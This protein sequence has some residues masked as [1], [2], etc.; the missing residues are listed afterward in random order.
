MFIGCLFLD[1]LPVL[2][3][4]QAAAPIPKAISIRQ[5]ASDQE[6]L[7]AY[8]VQRYVYLRT[9][10]LLK[11]RRG[12][13]TGDRIVVSCKDRSFCGEIGQDLAPQQFTLRT[14]RT[15]AGNLWWIVGGDAV[16]ALYGTYR[17]AEKLGVRFGIDEDILPQERLDGG[18]PEIEE[19]GKPRFALRGLQP[20]HD[21]SVGPDWWNLQDYKNVLS[22]MVKLR[23]NFF[24]L[25]TYP[26]WNPSAGPEANVWIGLP[27]DVDA[28]GNVRFGYESG[29]V[30]TRRGWEVK[31]YPTSRYA[32]GAG[33]F[34]E[35]D[36]YG[37]DFLLDWLDWPKTGDQ[38][39]AM[40]NQYGDF[41]ER[42]FTHA[43]RLGVKTC[44]GTEIPLGIPKGLA[45]CLEASEARLRPTRAFISADTGSL[46]CSLS[47]APRSLES[48]KP[49]KGRNRETGQNLT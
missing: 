45:A 26:S 35:S 47:R 32:S 48:L 33:L 44:V 11:V 49:G 17:F 41:Q 22:Q 37:P 13:G 43:R 20:F 5:E 10:K 29:V 39:A 9:G 27:E 4:T 31:P 8:E 19:T 14:S 23:M 7:A 38:A 1:L 6:R 21:F 2:L 25:H 36:D 12:S 30:T 16:G 40:F 24:G 15:K 18:M 3:P 42:A 34:F 28:H 46:P